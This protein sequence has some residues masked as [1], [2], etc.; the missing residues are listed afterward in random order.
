MQRRDVDFQSEGRKFHGYLAIPDG[1][2]PG[3]IVLHAW[4]GLTPFFKQFCDRLAAEGFVAFAPDLYGGPTAHTVEN[5]RSIMEASDGSYA[6]AAALAA[7][8]QMREYPF[9]RPG[10]LGVVGFSMGAAWSLALASRIPDEI[11]AAVLFYGTNQVDFNQVRAAILAHFA[12]NDAW[13]PLDGIQ[14]M[15]ADLR[16]AGREYTF[17]HYNGAGHW[18]FEDNRPDDFH[19]TAA[20]LA[21]VRTVDFLKEK[22]V[23]KTQDE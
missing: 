3:V 10:G 12:E 21:W 11:D 6:Q 13:E 19:E 20:G 22:L 2:G 8:R 18:F 5:A 17:H 4:W 14:L 23:G 7:V 1:G 15:E 16:A 9:V